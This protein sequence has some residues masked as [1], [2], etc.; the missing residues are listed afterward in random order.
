M[1]IERTY[2]RCILTEELDLLKLSTRV[3]HHIYSI[4]WRTLTKLS[5]W[6]PRQILLLRFQ[7]NYI[8]MYC[9][10]L[11]KILGC[12]IYE[13]CRYCKWFTWN[14]IT[15]LYYLNDSLVSWNILIKGLYQNNSHFAIFS[16]ILD[17]LPVL[18]FEMK[19][20][21]KKINLFRKRIIFIDYLKKGKIITMVH[22]CLISWWH[23]NCKK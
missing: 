1:H 19:K 13:T 2:L 21:I 6:M 3:C 20:K 18:T 7:R 10:L 23:V 16:F 22:F 4:G 9:I 14:K 5:A 12:L 11:L 17:N 15:K 8:I